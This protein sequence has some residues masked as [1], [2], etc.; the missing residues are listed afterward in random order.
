MGVDDVPAAAISQVLERIKPFYE[1]I[2]LDLGRL[3]ATSMGVLEGVD[4]VLVVTTTAVPSIYGAIL[5]VN[6]LKGGG[7]EEKQLSLIVNQSGKKKPLSEKEMDQLFGIQI[8]A[9]LSAVPDEMEEACQQKGLP[10]VNSVFRKQ[11][12]TL[13]RQVAGLPAP[14][15]KKSA[16][17]IQLF[18][19]NSIGEFQLDL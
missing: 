2:V 18:R 3:T 19:R 5:V 4:E 10:G 6:A 8:A 17:P 9:W 16:W 15:S 13:A 12:A 11:V 14:A 7:F 1:W